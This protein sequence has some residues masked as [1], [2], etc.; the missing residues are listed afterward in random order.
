[1]TIDHTRDPLGR[2]PVADDDGPA[3]GATH[4]LGVD[5]Q[6]E[7]HDDGERHRHYEDGSRLEWHGDARQDPE[8]W[9][10]VV[11]ISGVEVEATPPPAAPTGRPSD[12]S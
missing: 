7:P 1:V 9:A 11:L 4:W 8:S 6:A 2:L 12:P 5:C 10:P 3:C